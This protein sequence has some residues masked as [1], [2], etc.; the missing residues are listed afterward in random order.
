VLRVSADGPAPE[1]I[2]K[3]ARDVLAEFPLLT[4]EIL[5]RGVVL[6]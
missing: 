4:D 2:S 6:A 3:V 1:K 5:D